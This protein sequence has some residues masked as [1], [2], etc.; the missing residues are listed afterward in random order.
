MRKFRMIGVGMAGPGNDEDDDEDEDDDDSSRLI[1][2]AIICW[3]KNAERERET[4]FGL[5]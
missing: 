4:S 1:H 5:E 2:V 3:S